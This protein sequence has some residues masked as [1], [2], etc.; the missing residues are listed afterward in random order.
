MNEFDTVRPNYVSEQNLLLDCDPRLGVGVP[1]AIDTLGLWDSGPITYIF[2][3]I[4]RKHTDWIIAV[5]WPSTGPA[6][7]D[8]SEIT[9]EKLT[10]KHIKGI[11]N[12]IASLDATG[13]VPLAQ[14]PP[15]TSGF[16]VY[17]PKITA[18]DIANKFITL[19]SSPTIPANTVF[20]LPSGAPQVYEDDFIVIGN[21]LSWDGRGLDGNIYPDITGRV[22]IT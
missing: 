16:S 6:P 22:L 18:T 11:P 7:E 10:Q 19:P 5:E 14:L 2:M 8:A 15:I 17:Y 13:K 21:I 20:D 12:G 4:A 3:K 9:L 1:A